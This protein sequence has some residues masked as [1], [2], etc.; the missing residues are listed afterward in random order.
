MTEKLKKIN[1]KPVRCI[2]LKKD[3]GEVLEMKG[4]QKDTKAPFQLQRCVT[5]KTVG[6][7]GFKGI[8]MAKLQSYKQKY[9]LI[10]YIK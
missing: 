6:M 4:T 5:A 3:N 10:Y 8:F 1:G 2:W 7:T 9:T